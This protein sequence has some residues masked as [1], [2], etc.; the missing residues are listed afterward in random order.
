MA[1][2][3]ARAGGNRMAAAVTAPKHPWSGCEPKDDPVFLIQMLLPT[4][5]KGQVVAD[6]LL[7]ETRAE[8]IDAFGG[9]TAY[10][11]SPASGAWTSSTGDIELDTV[12][13]IE[14]LAETFD[15]DWWRP[16]ADRLQKRFSQDCIHIRAIP[17]DTLDS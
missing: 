10:S 1:L 12:V 14:I 2:R 3:D 7:A 9:L 15:K 5:T 4:R 8:I 11:R 13:M 17:I 6:T 16:Y